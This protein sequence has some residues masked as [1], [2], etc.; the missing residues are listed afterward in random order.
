MQMNSPFLVSIYFDMFFYFLFD[1]SYCFTLPYNNKNINIE[2]INK[3]ISNF[4]SC[5][6]QK[7][8][9]GSKQETD[10][11]QTEKIVSLNFSSLTFLEKY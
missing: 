5:S 10:L 7:V 9:G 11:N 2:K 6:Y 4:Y 8:I 3:L 1:S